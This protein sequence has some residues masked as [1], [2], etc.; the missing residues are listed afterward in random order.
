M[1]GN[2]VGHGCADCLDNDEDGLTDEAEPECHGITGWTVAIATDD[3]FHIESFTLD[4]TVTPAPFGSSPSRSPWSE[5][6]NRST[7]VYRG[8]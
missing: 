7:L 1:N 2:L 8:E 4:R 3:C 5:E 6:E